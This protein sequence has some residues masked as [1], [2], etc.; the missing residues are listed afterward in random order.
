[1][2]EGVLHGVLVILLL[3]AAWFGLCVGA[4]YVIFFAPVPF[5]LRG[6]RYHEPDQ[7]RC[8]SCGRWTGLRDVVVDAGATVC[9]TC[10]RPN[11]RP[12][13]LEFPRNAP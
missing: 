2:A 9:T 11:V 7:A 8:S 13:V 12:V 4:T 10:H 3:Q 6:G 1:M 5:G